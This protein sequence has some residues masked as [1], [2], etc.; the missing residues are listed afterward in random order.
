MFQL[1]IF[2]V[3]FPDSDAL[4][5]ASNVVRQGG[6]ARPSKPCSPLDPPSKIDVKG[7]GIC[8]A[9]FSPRFLINW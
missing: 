9:M 5:T 4:H 7:R 3:Q 2:N 1:S 8:D 6:S